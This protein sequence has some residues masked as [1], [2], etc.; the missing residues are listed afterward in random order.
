MNK[1]NFKLN[2]F[3]TQRQKRFFNNYYFASQI[4]KFIYYSAFEQ[5]NI[6]PNKNLFTK[7]KKD[8]FDISR[9]IQTITQ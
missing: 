2:L 5:I 8:F 9:K 3:I 7:G 6:Y 1:I 4:L